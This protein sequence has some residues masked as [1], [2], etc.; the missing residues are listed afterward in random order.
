MVSQQL[1]RIL[2]VTAFLL[3]LLTAAV[4]ARDGGSSAGAAAR[5]CD[6]GPA[7]RAFDFWLG[8]WEGE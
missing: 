7:A 1:K 2:I 6:H 4:L 5:P 3:T 8:E